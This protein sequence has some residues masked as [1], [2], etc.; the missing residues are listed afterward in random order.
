V[1][2]LYVRDDVGSVTR[3][4]RELRGFRKV[5]LEPGQSE[6]VRFT[7][8]PADLAFYDL[9]MVRVVE[10]GTFTVFVGGSSEATD[11]ATFTVEPIP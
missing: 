10:P 6:T 1:V 7:L 9:R 5:S 8:T 2:Q 4:V 11:S 3:P